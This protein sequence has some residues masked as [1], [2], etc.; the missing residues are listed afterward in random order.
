M[1]KE[2]Y[3]LWHLLNSELSTQHYAPEQEIDYDWS[4][5]DGPLKISVINISKTYTRSLWPRLGVD[6]EPRPLT[7]AS[8]NL[9][10]K[11]NNQHQPMGQYRG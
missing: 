3:V 10:S 8:A 6:Q 2:H 7:P 9:N 11:D 5:E 1:Q 4:G